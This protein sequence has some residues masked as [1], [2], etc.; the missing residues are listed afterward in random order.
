M[1]EL[2]YLYSIAL[3]FKAKYPYII[4]EVDDLVN[5]SYLI[6]NLLPDSYEKS[7]KN[8]SFNTFIYKK[9]WFH[10]LT[11]TRNDRA[12]LLNELNVIENDIS[13]SINGFQFPPKFLDSLSNEARRF[14]ETVLD[15]PDELKKYI[16][17]KKHLAFKYAIGHYLGFSFTQVENISKEVIAKF[18]Y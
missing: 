3:K 16:D 10:L 14:I 12:N 15:L 1:D 4:Q 17:N 2:K 11:I 13:Y 6:Y 5:E 8:C 18:I 7:K 9:V